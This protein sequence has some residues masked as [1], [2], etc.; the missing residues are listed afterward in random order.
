M[1]RLAAIDIGSNAIRLRIVD[2]DPPALGA[3]GGGREPALAGGSAGAL[4]AP[5]F[6]PFRDVHADRAPVRLGH[7]VF[8]KGRLES[9]VI[10]AACE[11]LRR[12]RTAMDAA[13]VD[14]YRAV[15]TSAAREAQNG[16]LFVERA[17]REAGVHVEVIEGVEE[18]RLVQ[19]AVLERVALGDRTALLVDVG[20]GSTELTLLRG[21]RAVFSRSL[22]VG[23]VR[24]VETFLEAR[25][26][27]DAGHRRLVEEYVDRVMADATREIVELL[28]EGS[29]SGVDLLVGT[30]GNIE[31]LADLCPLPGA[32]VEGRAID[33]AAMSRLLDE[34]VSKTPEERAQI[35][36][37][38]PERADT[39][40]PAATILSRVAQSFVQPLIVAP[41]VGLKEGV[42]VDLAHAHFLGP[43]FR[44]EAAAVSDAC[45][46]LGRRYHFDE[47]HGAL[48]ARFAE[49]LFDDLAPRHR[50]GQRDRI[51]L[52]A[53]ALLHDIGDFVRYEGHHKHSY[54]IIAHSDLMGLTPEERAIVANIARYHR[55]SPPSMDHDNFRAL[56]RDAR[57]KVKAMASIL[58]VA[59]A[60]DREHRAKVADV[61]GRI[62][63][64]TLVLEVQ[65]AEDRA[66]EEWTVVAKAGMLRDALGLDVRIVD[67]T[68]RSL[69]PASGATS[70]G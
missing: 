43:D 37:L 22:P 23:T 51:L 60:L 55:K 27:V 30:G 38:R 13:K 8:T 34:L 28:G 68:P 57:A 31:T 15:A 67:A 47:Q 12:F 9:G 66:L 1:A 45:T 5:R 41:G 33:V 16:D 64:D 58:R 52:R 48:V 50:L 69:P 49:R 29:G 44:G 63:E 59:D 2:V 20:G 18:A 11:A 25:R 62:E 3:F 21:R 36:G 4:D 10:G 53:A 39:I 65:G 17:A 14:R 6:H 35:Y 46:R 54:Y 70:G 40:V 26:P 7:D 32:P 24:M 42:L 61:S 19:L 56:S